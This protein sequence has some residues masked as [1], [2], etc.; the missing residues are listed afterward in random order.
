MPVCQWRATGTAG[1]ADISTSRVAVRAMSVAW[2]SLVSYHKLT[3]WFLLYLESSMSSYIYSLNNI[4]MLPILSCEL[5]YL[6]FLFD[7]TKLLILLLKNYSENII[8]PI[9][10]YLLKS[11]LQ[12]TNNIFKLNFGVT[13]LNQK[14]DYLIRT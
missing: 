8:A 12:N 13:Y 3:N 6:Y 10:L 11:R 4:S 1:H 5:H 9:V 14:G 2:Q 7:G